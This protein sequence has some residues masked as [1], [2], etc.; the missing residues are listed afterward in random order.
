MLCSN[1]IQLEVE[2]MT[3]WVSNTIPLL[4][5]ARSITTSSAKQVRRP[6]PSM[7]ATNLQP[8]SLGIE[9]EASFHL[10]Q[11]TSDRAVLYDIVTAEMTKAGLTAVRSSGGLIA[12]DRQTWRITNDPTITPQPGLEVQSPVF[13][14]NGSESDV[15][16]GD[17]NKALTALRSVSPTLIVNQSTGL[18]VHVGMNLPPDPDDMSLRLKRLALED[19]KKIAVLIISFERTST[20]MFSSF[21]Y[22]IYILWYIE[23]LDQI[24]QSHRLGNLHLRRF[25]GARFD[26]PKEKCR[27]ILECASYDAV[28]LLLQPDRQ[29][30]YKYNFWSL[31]KYGTV[32]FRQHAGCLVQS[33]VA[34]WVDFLLSF[35]R[36]AIGKEDDFLLELDDEMTLESIVGQEIMDSLMNSAE[37][38]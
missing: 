30:W 28:C 13:I 8:L 23:S 22:L 27:T 21:C 33:R 25:A 15:W 5:L 24:H 16:R 26:D 29:K 9:L 37:D 3:Q 7:S 4:F 38:S 17:L 14:D 1:P 12:L 10:P 35:V 32:E 34:A 6:I 11:P 31:P 20:I 2:I 18:H 19:V 36:F